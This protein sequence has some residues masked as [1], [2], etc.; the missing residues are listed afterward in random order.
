MKVLWRFINLVLIST[1][2]LSGH[3]YYPQLTRLWVIIERG[4]GGE[5]V[6]GRA[7]FCFESE[8]IGGGGSQE[9]ICLSL[10]DVFIIA[11]RDGDGIGRDFCLMTGFWG[12]GGPRKSRTRRIRA[13]TKPEPNRKS[14]LSQCSVLV[15]ERW[16]CWLLIF[17]LI[18]LIN[19]VYNFVLKKC[20]N[21]MQRLEIHY[22]PAIRKPIC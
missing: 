22:A 20:Y 21:L 1:Q 3:T 4:V 10:E 18:T 15:G 5:R 2:V 14:W 6:T 17:F 11:G 16:F 12:G 7:C 8:F 13:R 9:S 19:F